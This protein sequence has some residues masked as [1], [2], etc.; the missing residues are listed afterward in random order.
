MLSVLH[1]CTDFWPST[2]GI[3][4]FVREL[5]GRSRARGVD[6]AVLC[7][8]RSKNHRGR[9]PDEESIDGIPVMRAAFLDLHFYKPT[10]LSSARLRAYDL[11]H[12][13]GVGA[14][15]DYLSLLKWR[16]HRPI[17][18]S[19]H[20]AIFHTQTLRWLK[21]QYFHR[22][23]PLVLARVDLIAA[24]SR[25]DAELFSGFAPRVQLLENAT[26]VEPL[27]ALPLSQ[28]RRGRCLYVGRLAANKDLETLLRVFARA[29]AG[30]LS[31]ELR[32]VGKGSSHEVR[33][34]ETSAR[35][36]GLG[37]HVHFVGP[38]AS[39]EL[40]AEYGAADVFVSASRYEGFGL[41]AIEA[42]AA[43]C[44]LLLQ[45]NAAFRG[46]FGSDTGVVLTEY[47]S[48]EDAA[49]RLVELLQNEPPA[50]RH[51]RTAME[52]FAWSRKAGEWLDLYQKVVSGATRAPAVDDA[53]RA[54]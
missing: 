18:L 20:G 7:C 8:N 2:G 48:I 31:F 9:L 44:R 45:E 32:I 39:D 49:S 22:F 14:Q 47:R 54:A 33:R 27:L 36:L 10:W 17:V 34:L 28:K 30:G 21:Q 50:D 37:E 26:D 38:V 40:L 5:A 42:R 52:R 51:G 43:G 25:S 4:S 35:E 41:S 46:L 13:H 16:H 23:Q 24:C 6:A 15:L 3:Q 11:I 1:V 12:V 19:T 29:R 53:H